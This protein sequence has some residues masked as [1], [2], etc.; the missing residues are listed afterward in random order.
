MLFRI[1]RVTV[2][3]EARSTGA[4][5]VVTTGGGNRQDMLA[6]SGLHTG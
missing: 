5:G 2:D 3:R 6:R 1:T 4:V